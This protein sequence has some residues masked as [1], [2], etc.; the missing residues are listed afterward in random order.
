MTHLLLTCELSRV[1]VDR[2]WNAQNEQK[3][4]YRVTFAVILAVARAGPEDQLLSEAVS[5]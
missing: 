1:T 5:L 4:V 2:P 3:P